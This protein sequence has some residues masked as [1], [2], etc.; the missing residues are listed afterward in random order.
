MFGIG[1]Y[2]KPIY[3]GINVIVQPFIKRVVADGGYYEAIEC[4]KTKLNS[5]R[6]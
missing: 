3:K 6:V 4:L 5:L 2:I 1:L